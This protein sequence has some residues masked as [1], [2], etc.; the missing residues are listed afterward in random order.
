MSFAVFSHN[1]QDWL[2]SILQGADMQ[3]LLIDLHDEQYH[4]DPLVL[5]PEAFL[6]WRTR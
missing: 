4:P 1:E 5:R 3:L 6:Q 2:I